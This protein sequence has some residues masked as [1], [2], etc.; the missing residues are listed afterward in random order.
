M[1]VVEKISIDYHFKSSR[2][3]KGFIAETQLAQYFR[4]QGYE[5]VHLRNGGT[6]LIISR[7]GTSHKIEC[8]FASRGNDGKWRATTIKIDSTDHRKSDFI[9]FLCQLPYGGGECVPF[10]IPVS[11][12]G[13]K[14]HI[15][16]TSNPA[17]YSGKYSEY[18][19]NWKLIQ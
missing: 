1:S 7:N 17:T 19:N 11:A 12:Q 15:V 9:V 14:P 10:I 5:V 4:T 18:R 2:A 3:R 16:I 13:N 6:D 8:K